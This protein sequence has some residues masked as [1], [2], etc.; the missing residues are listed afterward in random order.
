MSLRND[1]S[2]PKTFGS[3][4]SELI[5]IID[6]S[7]KTISDKQ[8]KTSAEKWLQRYLPLA[9]QFNNK[10]KAQTVFIKLQASVT[11]ARL[12]REDW[13]RGLRIILKEF[14]NMNLSSAKSGLI[15]N[16]TQSVIS[17]GVLSN[18][19]SKDNKVYVLAREVNTSWETGCWNSCGILMRIILERA[20][21][22]K[23]SDLRSEGLKRK[24][25]VSLSDKT[26][27]KSV[28]EALSKLDNSTKI[29][30]DIVAH[31]SN[32]ILDKNDIELAIVPLNVL[33]KDIY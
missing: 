8:V 20:L 12:I 25:S 17:Q 27:G 9:P 5:K 21:D 14:K 29:S 2:S 11:N 28:A 18:L 22:K 7:A 15:L 16:P 4:T 23:R 13:L 3:D 19:K 24:I 6:R 30:G 26:F 1:S 32:I 31:D 33:L 10:G